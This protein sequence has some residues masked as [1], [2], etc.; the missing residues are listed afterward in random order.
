MHAKC[1]LMNRHW[2]CV[3][4]EKFCNITAYN[5]CS[6]SWLSL[7]LYIGSERVWKENAMRQKNIQINDKSRAATIII[8]P[9]HSGPFLKWLAVLFTEFCKFFLPSDSVLPEIMYNHKN[10]SFVSLCDVLIRKSCV[11]ISLIPVWNQMVA[12]CAEHGFI[13]AIIWFYSIASLARL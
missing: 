5:E 10:E 13:A 11:W 3:F 4:L 7:C 8:E 2:W 9:T 12:E 6:L 1:R